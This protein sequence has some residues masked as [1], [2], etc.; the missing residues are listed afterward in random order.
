M[1][2]ESVTGDGIDENILGVIF[3]ENLAGEKKYKWLNQ[4]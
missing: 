4:K 2:V 1:K 3:E